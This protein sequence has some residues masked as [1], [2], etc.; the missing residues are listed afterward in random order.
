MNDTKLARAMPAWQEAQ[1]AADAISARIIAEL[2]ARGNSLKV[3]NVVASYR[4]GT[5][6][7]DYERGFMDAL[8]K[9]AYDP[10][11]QMV[12]RAILDDH[13][14]EAIDWKAA[15]EAAQIVAP[16]NPPGKPSV[17]LKIVKK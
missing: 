4:K 13:K 9:V 11:Q 6:T 17:S 5:V 12:L 16:E 8:Q 1:E 7:R 15:C 10:S 2:L 14:K 3:G